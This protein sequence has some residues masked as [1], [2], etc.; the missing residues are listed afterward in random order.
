MIYIYNKTTTTT[1]DIYSALSFT[2]LSLLGKAFKGKFMCHKSETK[3]L[4]SNIIKLL[5]KVKTISN[6][7]N[8]H[9]C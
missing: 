6:F 4:W 3:Y 7:V 2:A 9:T 5:F 8:T 1:T